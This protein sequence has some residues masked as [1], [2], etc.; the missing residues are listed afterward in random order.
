L[1][2]AAKMEANRLLGVFLM[3]LLLPFDKN[4]NSAK[5]FSIEFKPGDFGDRH[6][7]FTPAS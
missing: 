4:F 1:N 3:I 2:P 6:I 5:N 7:R